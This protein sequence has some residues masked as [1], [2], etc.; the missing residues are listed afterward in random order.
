MFFV[1]SAFCDKVE[2]QNMQR[3]KVEWFKALEFRIPGNLVISLFFAAHL[4]IMDFFYSQGCF[5]KPSISTLPITYRC[6]S[7]SKSMVEM[8][9]GNSLVSL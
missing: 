1:L 6:T 8:G 9:I 4:K 3:K 7:F 2:K 5:Y